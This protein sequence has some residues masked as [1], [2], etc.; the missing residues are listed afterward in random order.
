MH[1][2]PLLERLDLLY[3]GPTV[4]GVLHVQSEQGLVSDGAKRPQI[5]VVKMVETLE[6]SG[7]EGIAHLLVGKQRSPF[8]P[9][10]AA[11]PNHQA[12]FSL[13]DWLQQPASILR[14]IAPIDV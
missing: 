7:S 8:R 4:V 13:P 14:V 6:E 9:R 11:D 12:G 1:S 2:Q 5:D 3:N 10:T